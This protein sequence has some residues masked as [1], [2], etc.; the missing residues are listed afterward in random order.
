MKKMKELYHAIGSDKEDME[1]LQECIQKMEEYQI[2]LF[3]S[4]ILKSKIEQ[5]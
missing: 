5:E 4:F 1:L 3:R 2:P